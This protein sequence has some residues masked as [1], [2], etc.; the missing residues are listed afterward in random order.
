MKRSKKPAAKTAPPKAKLLV[1]SRVAPGELSSLQAANLI[2]L[3]RARLYELV[4]EGR[5]KMKAPNCFDTAEVVHG[6]IKFLRDDER[7]SSKSATLSRVQQARAVEIEQRT[8]RASAQTV[9][10]SEA[11]ALVDVV[12][13]GFKA[14]LNGL[15]ARLTRDMDERRRLEAEINDILTRAADRTRSRKRGS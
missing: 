8:A 14:D 2:L 3:S 12:I 5:I 15:P 1:K 4:R 11:L 7:R 10:L 6:Y 13:G 9:E